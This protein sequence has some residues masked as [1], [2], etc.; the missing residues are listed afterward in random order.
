MAASLS[1]SIHNPRGCESE[2]RS[3]K[4]NRHNKPEEIFH[5]L[6]LNSKEL[7]GAM[8]HDK[9]FFD[10]KLYF[11]MLAD[12]QYLEDNIKSHSRNWEWTYVAE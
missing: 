12:I 5:R 1:G 11:I 9:Q 4:M 6:D 7:E 8:K 3:V 10:R 2:K